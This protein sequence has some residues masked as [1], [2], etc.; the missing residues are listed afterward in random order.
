MSSNP[1][2]NVLKRD[3][4]V[5][6]DPF[7]T[8]TS[9]ATMSTKNGSVDTPEVFGEFAVLDNKVSQAIND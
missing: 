9:R 7:F 3:H 4:L 8:T 6:R 1:R 5:L 2:E